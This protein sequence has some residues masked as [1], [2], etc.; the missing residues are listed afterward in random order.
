MR[1]V[2]SETFTLNIDPADRSDDGSALWSTGATGRRRERADG[3]DDAMGPITR[4]TANEG[5]APR[6]DS[7]DLLRGRKTLTIHHAGQDYTLRLTR[8]GKLLLTK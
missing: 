1:H 2:R 6:I 8:L 5:A 4:L 7:S 3:L